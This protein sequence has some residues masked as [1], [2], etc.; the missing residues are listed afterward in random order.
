LLKQYLPKGIEI[1]GYSQPQLNVIA[2]QLKRRPRKTLGFLTRA[3]MFSERVALT[4]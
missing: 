3:E 1:S 2:R 4:G